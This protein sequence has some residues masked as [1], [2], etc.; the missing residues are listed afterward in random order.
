MA[1]FHASGYEKDFPHWSTASQIHQVAWGGHVEV[2]GCG[3]LIFP[4]IDGKIEILE[5]AIHMPNRRNRIL[6]TARLERQAI[7]IK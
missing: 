3:N 1:A 6:S 5:G 7:A 2:T 4:T